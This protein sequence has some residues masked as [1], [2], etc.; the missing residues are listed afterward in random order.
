MAWLSLDIMLM[1]PRS[2]D[3]FGG[4][5]LFADAAFGKGQVFGNAGIR[6]GGRP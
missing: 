3:V 6:G 5:G 4:D 1:A 2:Q